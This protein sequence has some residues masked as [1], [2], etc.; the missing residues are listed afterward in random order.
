TKRNSNI[1]FHH[2]ALAYDEIEEWF[3]EQGNVTK[4]A[5][6]IH[7]A[8][9]EWVYV[10]WY[11]APEGTNPNDLFTRL[12]RDRIPLTDSELI[13]ALVLSNSGAAA[14]Q[15]GRQEEVAALWDG[16]ERDLRDDQFWAFLTGRT[17]K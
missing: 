3:G 17:A 4:A 12:N 5:S 13:K 8:L 9:S 10:I 2:I 11:Q 1:D 14:G 15:P 6:D 7:T 16:F